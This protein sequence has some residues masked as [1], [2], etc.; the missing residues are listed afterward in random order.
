MLADFAEPASGGGGTGE[1]GGDETDSERLIG[2]DAIQSR[3]EQI[4]DKAT[5]SVCTCMPGSGHSPA[6]IEA[7]RHNDAQTLLRGVE[8][9]TVCLGAS[10]TARR[11]SSTPAG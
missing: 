11:R 9:R 2:M 5:T 8:P 6:S 3:L 7:A 10:A 4:A 1:A